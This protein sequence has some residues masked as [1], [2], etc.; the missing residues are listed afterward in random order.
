MK[1][2]SVM[3]PTPSIKW[4]GGRGHVV[5]VVN[6]MI[7]FI[8]GFVFS[9]RFL[10]YYPTHW[11]LGQ[12]PPKALLFIVSFSKFHLLICQNGGE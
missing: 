9:V 3:A 1:I 5:A 4:K 12:D 2:F 7:K 6:L 8:M 10:N 11:P